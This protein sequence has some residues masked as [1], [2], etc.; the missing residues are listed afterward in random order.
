MVCVEPATTSPGSWWRGEQSSTPSGSGARQRERFSKII[1]EMTAEEWQAI[2][3][4]PC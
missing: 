1:D 2:E 3:A 4:P